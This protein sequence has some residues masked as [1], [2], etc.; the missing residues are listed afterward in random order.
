MPTSSDDVTFDSNSGA[1]ATVTITGATANANTITINKADLTLF[2][3]AGSTVVGLVLLTTGSINTNGQTCSWSR[4]DSN[5]ANTRSITFG[6]SGITLT[7]SGQAAWNVN[8]ATGLTLSAAS[9][10]ITVSAA[11]AWTVTSGQNYGTVNI[12]IAS[13]VTFTF[14]GA[15]NYAAI[16]LTGAAAKNPMFSLST[17]L[18]VTG[19]FT[20]NGN[21][22]INRVCV[23]SSTVGT[24]RTITAATVSVTNS[25]FQDITGAGAGSWNLSAITGNSG[26][27][28]G[29]SGITFTT[30]ATQTWS[31]TS[32]GNWSANAWTSRVPLPQ[33]DVVINA[34]FSASQTVTADMPRLGKSIDL[35]GATGTPTLSISVG[36]SIFG[37]LTFI[38]GMTVSGASAVT[39]A[40][41]SSYTITSAGK[42]FPATNNIT[43]PGGTYTLQDAFST[44]GAFALNNGVFNANNFNVTYSTFSSSNTNTRTLTMGSGAWTI[45]STAAAG[46]WTLS[47][48]TGLTFSGAS[49]TIVISTT[50]A[51]TRTFLGGGLT[52]GTLTYIIAGS[53]GG[54]DITG[55]NIFTTIN[56]SDVTN[57]RTLRF[58]AG[59]T[60]TVTNFNV[61]GTSGKLMSVSS[62]T[63]ATH[64]ISKSSGIVSCDYLSLTNSIATGG[65]TFY[66]GANSTNVS[67]NTGWI[68]SAPPAG[69]GGGGER[70]ALQSLANLQNLRNL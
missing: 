58:T 65:A 43:A 13:G 59:T 10:T 37:S 48:T 36:L 49:A 5:N 15:G 60:T 52:Y 41:R 40:G 34:A 12:T 32:G 50:S 20:C 56:F 1:A 26:D 24:A 45:T 46:V 17:A 31:G 53:T 57:A 66:A 39:F 69:S 8:N 14:Q 61:N 11:N 23:Q 4:F 7:T 2:H 33:D 21:S 35:T 18:T 6:A 29:N 64:T 67:G 44:A 55:S 38:S 68:F 63:A 25:D 42:Q 54:L 27:C 22:S 51:N 3:S 19:T 47:T 62:I 9:S 16:T 30:P 28:G 70:A